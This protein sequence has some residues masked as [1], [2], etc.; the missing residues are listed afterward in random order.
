MS[1][2]E[3]TVEDVGFDL[4]TWKFVDN[5]MRLLISPRLHL[6]VCRVAVQ[7]DIM[8]QAVVG[9]SALGS[10]LAIQVDARSLPLNTAAGTT[11]QAHV[12]RTTSVKRIIKGSQWALYSL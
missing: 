7:E 10:V 1:N 9:E 8:L 4:V 3:F 12:L 5:L 2:L 11:G 6:H